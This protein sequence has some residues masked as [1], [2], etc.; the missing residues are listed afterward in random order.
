[1]NHKKLKRFITAKLKAKP[2]ERNIYIWDIVLGFISNDLLNV[3]C[4][5][6][7]S[8]SYW[9]KLL[10]THTHTQQQQQ[11]KKKKKWTHSEH[12]NLPLLFKYLVRMTY[13]MVFGWCSW[14]ELIYLTIWRMLRRCFEWSNLCNIPSSPFQHKRYC[15]NQYQ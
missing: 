5:F 15:S 14:V 11:Q 1:V 6:E 8:I 3:H 12:N 4:M 13:W 7:I 10:K 2:F 9:S